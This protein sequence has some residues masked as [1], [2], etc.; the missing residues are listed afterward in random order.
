MVSGVKKTSSKKKPVISY[1]SKEK[2]FC[3]VCKKNF[4]KEVMMR[5]QE[6]R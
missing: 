3:P 2:C 6:I 5:R 4:E 1:W